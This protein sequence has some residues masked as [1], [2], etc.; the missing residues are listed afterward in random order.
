MSRTH[1]AARTSGTKRHIFTQKY[2]IYILQ[3]HD[4]T[5]NTTV[6]GTQHGQVQP[7]S[8]GSLRFSVTREAWEPGWAKSPEPGLA[9]WMACVQF[10]LLPLA[11]FV[12]DNTKLKSSFILVNSQLVG[13]PP[14]R[15]D[16]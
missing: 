3:P 8:Q 13:I 11:G 2:Y 15:R 1:K 10:L 9:I 16:Y 12:L 6:L 4:S 7:S 5:F 14:A